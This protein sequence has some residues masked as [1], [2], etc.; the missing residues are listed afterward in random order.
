M[1]FAGTG[2]AADVLSSSLPTSPCGAGRCILSVMRSHVLC[3]GPAWPE[4]PSR[5]QKCWLNLLG[6]GCSCFRREGEE[7]ASLP[8]PHAPCP[9][10][11]ITNIP[12]GTLSWGPPQ[13]RPAK[14]QASILK[15]RGVSRARLA[16]VPTRARRGFQK[17]PSSS[18]EE[19]PCPGVTPALC[20][21]PIS[22][23]PSHFQSRSKAARTA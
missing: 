23:T 21:S 10:R 18:W 11:G 17:L 6:A 22:P 14:P 13:T 2:P 12:A 8:S 5:V 9:W 3:P 16:G 20:S 19:V 15:P 7:G 4:L 1:C